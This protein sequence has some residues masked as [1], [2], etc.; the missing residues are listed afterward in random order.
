MGST[1]GHD[2]QQI[3]DEPAEMRDGTLLRSDIYRPSGG[4]KTTRSS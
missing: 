2:V 3:R 1:Q 4:G